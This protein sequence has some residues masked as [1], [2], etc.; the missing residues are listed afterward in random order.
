M[1]HAVCADVVLLQQL[2]LQRLRQVL[3]CGARV[4][5]VRVA[6]GLWGR[7]H[8]AAEEAVGGA[9]RVEAAIDVEEAVSL[10]AVRAGRV[11]V[12]EVAVC[13]E[14]SGVEELDVLV[15]HLAARPQV[16]A[17]VVQ[18]AELAGELDVRVICQSCVAE[19]TDAIL[20]TEHIS[21]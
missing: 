15:P 4:G 19:D 5:K 11:R 21:V 18:V 7:Q 6:A 20:F 3:P 1:R 12:D 16:A 17:D 10:V 8:D 13:V 14:V 9:A 2:R